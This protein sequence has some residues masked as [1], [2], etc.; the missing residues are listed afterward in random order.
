ME[1]KKV[2]KDALLEKVSGGSDEDWF[3]DF[4]CEK[5][6]QPY[7]VSGWIDTYTCPGCGAELNCIDH[8]YCDARNRSDDILLPH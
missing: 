7:N 4:N 8:T 5:C 3:S 2:L 6:H 1:D